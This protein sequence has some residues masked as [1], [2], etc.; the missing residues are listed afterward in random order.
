MSSNPLM[1]DYEGGDLLLAGTACG[2]LLG[3]CA[4]LCVQAL[5]SDLN[6]AWR[7]SFSEEIA[8]EVSIHETHYTN[9]R[10]TFTLPFTGI[11][12][13]I[14][15]ILDILLIELQVLN[16]TLSQVTESFPDLVHSFISYLTFNQ[17]SVYGAD[18][19]THC[20]I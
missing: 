5:G 19:I 8:L 9:R 15:I 1:M 3:H 6:T 20:M 12:L 18:I 2:R 7:L 13:L 16:N 11:L 4:G 10:L 17:D 14:L